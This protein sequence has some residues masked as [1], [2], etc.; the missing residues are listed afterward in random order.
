MKISPHPKIEPG[1]TLMSGLSLSMEPSPTPTPYHTV[2]CLFQTVLIIL[3]RNGRYNQVDKELDLRGCCGFA[4]LG[5][6]LLERNT[7][8]RGAIGRMEEVHKQDCRTANCSDAYLSHGESLQFIKAEYPRCQPT[9]QITTFQC[10]GK[11][12]ESCMLNL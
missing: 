12:F 1:L 7:V 11:C 2:R 9:T 3:I 4:E 6:K 10:E 8:V 5:L